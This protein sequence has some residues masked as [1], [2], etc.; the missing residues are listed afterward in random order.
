MQGEE[1]GDI[2]RLR[3]RQDAVRHGG[4]PIRRRV[5]TLGVVASATLLIALSSTVG[6]RSLRGV[7]DPSFGHNGKTFAKAPPARAHSEYGAMLRQPDGALVLEL[8]REVPRSEGGIREIERRLPDGSLDPS[9]DGDG[10]VIVAA[11]QGIA[12]R[13][14]GSILVAIS[15]CSGKGASMILLG[16]GGAKDLGFGTNGCAQSLPFSASLISVAPDGRILVAGSLPYCPPCGHDLIPHR[17]T[18]VARLLPDGS[19]DGSFGNDGVVRTRADLG[20]PTGGF[21]EES[22]SPTG[23]VA[24]D[25]GGAL[26]SAGKLLFRLDAGG[27]LAAG[28][29]KGGL[30]E[31]T[32][33]IAGLLSTP[34]GAIT[35][36]STQSEPEYTESGEIVAS[37]FR[38]DGTPEPGFGSGGSTQLA[39]ASDARARGIAPAPGEG[40]LIAGELLAGKDCRAICPPTPILV[41]LGSNGQLDPGYGSGGVAAPQR[42][43]SQDYLGSLGISAL[44]TAPDGA[45]L[46]AGGLYVDDAFVIAQAPDGSP[47]GA[48]GDSGMLIERHYLPPNLEVS[49]LALGRGGGFTV[50]AEGTPESAY[51]GGYLIHFR[52]NGRQVRGRSGKGVARTPARGEIQSTRGGRVVSWWEGQHYVLGVGKHGGLASNYGHRGRVDLPRGFKAQAIDAG[53]RGSVTVVGTVGEQR[54]LAVYRLGPRGRPLAGFGRR[55][56]AEVPFGRAHAV[57]FAALVERDGGVVVTG[58]VGGH[59][60]I[61]RLMPNGHLD[62]RFGNRGRLSSLLRSGSYGT[63]IAPFRGGIVVAATN[64]KTV[65]YSLAGV[66]RLDRRGHPVRGF[67]RRGVIHPHTRAR[68]LSLLTAAGRIVLLTD[69]GARHRNGGAELRAYRPNGSVAKRFGR[70]GVARAGV[71]QPKYFQPVTAVR[72]REG[73]IVVAGSAW[74][75]EYG[76][77]ELLRFR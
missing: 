29:G 43:P 42:P 21:G 45:A 34:D 73:K 12:L 65:H 76:Q 64:E 1:Q 15:S 8:R 68:P 61:A 72:Q 13:A 28:F 3:S 31:V 38:L 2:T 60:G 58:W 25:E 26:V 69:I 27:A 30:V 56:L 44:A 59:V 16:S 51:Y 6:A 36:A 17:E 23:I 57:A 46:L 55:G 77:A 63:Q 62:R 75:G 70:G 54:A 9:F 41:R 47:N 11:G 32:G 40:T 5:A 35:V 20:V 50:A 22:L 49:G 67:G 24:N 74:N 37:R 66:I 10:R 71:A 39:L 53:P 19:L 18:A 33:R 7:L 48:F 4:K 52:R 14:D